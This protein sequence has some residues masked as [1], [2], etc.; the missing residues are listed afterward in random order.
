MSHFWTSS[1]FP[2]RDKREADLSPT[3]GTLGSNGHLIEKLIL[4]LRQPHQLKALGAAT[5][6]R[7][8]DVPRTLRIILMSITGR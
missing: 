5:D 2:L 8:H 1:V 6:L 7:C 4:V 3:V